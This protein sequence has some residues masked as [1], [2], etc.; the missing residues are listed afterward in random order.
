M[1]LSTSS[2]R[3]AGEGKGENAREMEEL[4]GTGRTGGFISAGAA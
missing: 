1:A 2:W 4:E 3:S